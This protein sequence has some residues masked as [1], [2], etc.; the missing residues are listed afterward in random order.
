MVVTSQLS[1]WLKKG[2]GLLVRSTLRA[3]PDT[4]LNHARIRV[5]QMLR[6][7]TY[8][9]IGAAIL[10]GFVVGLGP[11][12]SEGQITFKNIDP[13]KMEGIIPLQEPI[14]PSM[15]YLPKPRL[16]Q[17]NIRPEHIQFEPLLKS[18]IVQ[19]NLRPQQ[20]MPGVIPQDAMSQRNI[21][22]EWLHREAVGPERLTPQ[23]LVT[24]GSFRFRS[25]IFMPATQP[26]PHLD[27]SM[28]LA[29]SLFDDRP[30]NTAKAGA[31]P[32]AR[33]AAERPPAVRRPSRPG[34]GW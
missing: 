9:G 24:R 16:Y 14:Q 26:R 31:S 25:P 27:E 30:V 17:D 13:R 19:K 22:P 10:F 34:L 2:A 18:N 23:T 1:A 5:T 20:L 32:H 12:E 8:R 11:T 15:P 4:L 33:Q 6:M 21:A 29:P 3:V 7:V 28:M